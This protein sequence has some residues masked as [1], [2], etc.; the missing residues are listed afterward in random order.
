MKI[1]KLIRQV[2]L[3]AMM[4][5]AMQPVAFAATPGNAAPLGLELG[6][7]TSA[8]VA[9]MAPKHEDAGMNAYSK[10]PQW[11]TDGTEAGVD[12]VKGISYLFDRSNVLVG[13][14]VRFPKDPK[15]MM[16]IL[17]AKYRLVSNKVDTFMNYGTARYQ[18]GDSYIDIHA[19]HLSFDM[20]VTYT[21]KGLM[22]SFT[23]DVATKRVVEGQAKAQKF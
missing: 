14:I 9:S 18:K 23:N 7:S 19:P 22:A 20:T 2:I 5:V 13:V 17:S 1:L 15:G 12:G 3:T 6:K 16:K 8:D 10:G 11:N 21:T 4:T